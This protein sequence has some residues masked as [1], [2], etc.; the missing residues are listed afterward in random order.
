M[1]KIL[2]VDDMREFLN[3]QT[4]L[5]Q[6]AGFP[7]EFRTADNPKAALDL[8]AREHIDL[9]ILDL[10]M[11]TKDGAQLLHEIKRRF[12]KT[13][14]A[15]YSGYVSDY[16]ASELFKAG[17]DE[18]LTKPCPPERLMKTIESLL[19]PEKDCTIVIIHGYNL[20]EFRNQ[21]LPTMLQKAL[22]KSDSNVSRAAD[23]LGVSRRCLTNMLKRFGIIR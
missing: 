21:V 11:P 20:K 5:L 8:L 13:K 16:N 18:I 4:K 23:L 17:A 22:S 3:E 9:V 2:F 15:I 14:V 1:A 10:M 19:R 6:E 12:K 7:H